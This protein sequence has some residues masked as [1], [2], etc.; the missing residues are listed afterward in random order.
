MKLNILTTLACS[1][2]CALAEVPIN[3]IGKTKD[4]IRGD[5]STLQYQ[6]LNIPA[7]DPSS[8]RYNVRMYVMGCL[9]AVSSEPY[10]KGTIITPDTR[11]GDIATIFLS[12]VVYCANSMRSMGDQLLKEERYG[13]AVVVKENVVT[14]NDLDFL[15][16]PDTQITNAIQGCNDLGSLCFEVG[17]FECSQRAFAKAAHI[18]TSNNVENEEMCELIIKVAASQYKSGN[19]SDAAESYQQALRFLKKLGSAEKERMATVSSSLAAAMFQMKNYADAENTYR[20]ALSLLKSLPQKN[21]YLIA[22][23]TKHLASCLFAQRLWLDSVSFYEEALNLFVSVISDTDEDPQ[24]DSAEFSSLLDTVVIALTNAAEDAAKAGNYRDAHALRERA[25]EANRIWAS[26]GKIS[27]KNSAFL[28]QLFKNTGMSADGGLPQQS[29]GKVGVLTWLFRAVFAALVG[30]VIY[31]FVSVIDWAQPVPP[32]LNALQKRVLIMIGHA[33]PD[34]EQ[35]EEVVAGQW[36]SFPTP[37]RY[38]GA[39]AAKKAKPVVNPSP[40]RYFKDA[41]PVI[42]P[43]RQQTPV[44][45]P[46]E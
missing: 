8:F 30:L 1:V 13:E 18:M 11:Y 2:A 35:E 41:N 5:I 14:L 12:D 40:D 16:S 20:N 9:M 15:S 24:N 23:T 27:K 25:A 4:Q 17:N 10:I 19:Y 42:S 39:V 22:I 38:S 46:S 26:Q 3:F 33:S 36:S 45:I 7:S 28:E 34:G 32:Q 44:Y 29:R 43:P 31:V 21:Y 37:E 6:I